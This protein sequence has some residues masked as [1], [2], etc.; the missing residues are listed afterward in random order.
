MPNIWFIPS[1]PTLESWLV[2]MG[3][4]D[5]DLIDISVTTSSEQ[6]VTEWMGFESLADFLDP[7]DPQKTIEGYP[8]PK[9]A[10]VLARNS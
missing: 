1:V 2:K 10:M 5:I 4:S 8:A 3:F 9:R 6:R 7:D